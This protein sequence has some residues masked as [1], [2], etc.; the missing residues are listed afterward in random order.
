MNRLLCN[1]VIVCLLI[2]SASVEASPI[3]AK[4]SGD[5]IE[6]S[7]ATFDGDEIQPLVWQPSSKFHMLP[8]RRWS[9]GFY[10]NSQNKLTFKSTNGARV[11]TSFKHT[12]I[13]FRTSSKFKQT[14]Q[15]I[16][17][18]PRCQTQLITGGDIK[19]RANSSCGANFTLDQGS[20]WRPFDFFRPSFELP[21]LL[22]DFRN[23]K[24]P[25]GRYSAVFDEPVAY[26]LIYEHNEVESYQIYHDQVEVIID[27]QP[28]FLD[29][30][31]VLGDGIFDVK[32]DTENHTASGSTRYKVQ[33][34]GYIEPGIKMRFKSSGPQEDDFSLEEVTSKSKIPYDLVCDACV[35][36]QIIK[37]G[38]MKK[39]FAKIDFEGHF[40]DFNL[41]FSFDNLRYGDVN[42]GDYSDAVTVIFEIDI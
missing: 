17:S 33:V 11:T 1:A 6:W 5:K 35:E 15:V 9:P 21:S 42:E 10:Q 41:D 24:L 25:A 37:E 13:D 26:Y 3:Y 2:V 40:L 22:D 14:T 31:T 19:L 34:S 8:I 7:N 39:D 28:S 18:A 20:D 12:G 30:V 38:V 4:I 29:S 16:G 32:Y 36:H 27:Y 23:A